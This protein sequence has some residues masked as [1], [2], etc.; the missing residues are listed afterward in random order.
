MGWEPIAGRHAITHARFICVFKEPLPPKSLRVAQELVS[1]KAS[2]LSLNIAE[3][4]PEG[5]M[6]L[7]IHIGP[8]QQVSAGPRSVQ[9]T[10]RIFKRQF[11]HGVGPTGTQTAEELGLRDYCFGYVASEYNRW[12]DFLERL[13]TVMGS[14]LERAMSVTDVASIQLEY[15]NLFVFNDALA[16]F[17][18]GGLFRRPFSHVPEQ[19]VSPTDQWEVSMS[20]S[21]NSD[22]LVAREQ[23]LRQYRGV[24]VHQARPERVLPGMQI[25]NGLTAVLTEQE[26]DLETVWASLDVMHRLVMQEFHRTMSD[27]MNERLN[28][29]PDDYMLPS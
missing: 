1:A 15:H 14:P 26:L 18:V 3:P 21:K 4:A 17:G 22:Y 9:P 6:G 29:R 13:R 24:Q 7:Q 2:E 28:I 27:Q 19:A 25:V 10:G 23:Y 8:D 5:G 20:W 11:A 16:A 12:A